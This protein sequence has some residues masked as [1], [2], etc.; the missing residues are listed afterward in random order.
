M[1]NLDA[2][3]VLSMEGAVAHILLNNPAKHNSLTAAGIDLFIDCLNQVDANRDIRVLVITGQG[4]K[5][6]CA[7]ASLEEV[8]SGDLTGDK[9]ETLTDRLT[10]MP[11][12]VICALNGSVYGGGSEIA[13]CCDFRIGVYGMRLKVPAAEIG[14]CYPPNGIRRYVK[15]LGV[16]TAKRILVA[17]EVL[18]AEMLLRA[19]YLTHLVLQ[20]E[21]EVE[22]SKLVG[23]LTPLSP[24]AVSVM[25]QLCDQAADGNVDPADTLALTLRCHRSGDLQEGLR[26]RWENRQPNFTHR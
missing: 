7:G 14:L 4:E 25:K 24:T 13:L 19:G 17:A 26:A 6:F 1:S 22:T 16:T 3:V 10:A 21:L 11:M 20:D 2:P 5:T 12:P 8:T 23:T 9:L 18:D 15:R